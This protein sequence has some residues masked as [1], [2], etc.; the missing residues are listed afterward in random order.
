MIGVPSTWGRYSKPMIIHNIGLFFKITILMLSLLEDS[1]Y[2]DFCTQ[3][4]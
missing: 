3:I 2:L 1:K 4:S